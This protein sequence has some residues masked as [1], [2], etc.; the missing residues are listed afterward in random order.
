MEIRRLTETYAVS[1]Q[2]MPEDVATIRDEGFVRV[3]CNRPDGK[4]RPRCTR[5]KCASWSWRRGWNS[6]TIR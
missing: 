2:I 4:S 3:V 5:K 1:P 6:S